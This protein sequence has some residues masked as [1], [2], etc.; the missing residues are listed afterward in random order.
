MQTAFS[1]QLLA[2]DSGHRAEEILRSCVHCGFC[3]ATCPTYQVTGSELD[4]P[5]GR[6]YLIKEMLEDKPVSAVTRNHLDRCL[7]C[8][9]CETTCPSGV[10][11]H[12]LLAIGRSEIQR[13]APRGAAA[14]LMRRLLTAVMARR[15][16]ATPLLRTGRLLRG[17][18]PGRLKQ[19]LPANRSPVEVRPGDHERWVVL[20]Q[21]C[22]QPGLSPQT[23]DAARLLLDRLG[24]EGRTAAGETCCGALGYHLDGQQAALRQ[25]RSNVDAWH[26]ALEDG[27]EAIV[28]TASG[29]SNFVLDYPQLL[30]DD[31]GY[32]EKART[33]VA[34]LRD[35]SQLLLA[36]DLSAL[37]P[38]RPARVAWHCP[39]TAQHGQQLDAPV[40][41]VLARL[42]YELPEIAD[43]HLCCGSAGAWSL[44][45]G[46]LAEQ[47]RT[48][49]LAALEVH[50]PDFIVTANV[51]CQVHLAAATDRPVVHWVELV[52]RQLQATL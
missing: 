5:R 18:V 12:S 48:D 36:E 49:K 17:L 47:L 29:C 4:S 6:I 39:C 30:A 25:V 52:A 13:R 38:A 43:G 26:Q 22:V 35:V 10:D 51:G 24:V 11:Y 31:P 33:V 44:F 27:A 28:L 37:K 3:L 7:T 15:R 45:H 1:P 2:S 8:R 50:D 23:R 40:R 14:R 16:L 20:A 21:G 34:G 19:A 46:E 41:E 32:A 9:A 42:G